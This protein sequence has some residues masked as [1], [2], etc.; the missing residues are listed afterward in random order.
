MPT[1]VILGNFTQEGV[2][3]IKDSPRR[4]EDSAKLAKSLGG[5]MK[6]FYYTMGRYDFIGITEVPN[7]EAAMKG[8]LIL[9]SKGAVRTE[10][11]VAIPA[12]KVAEII[13]ELP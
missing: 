9:G 13:K 5:E 10:T 1:Y 12:E 2:E 6:A 4:L 3:N 11:L 7:N 8:L